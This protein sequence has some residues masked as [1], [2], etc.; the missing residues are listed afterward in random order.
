[1]QEDA[2]ESTL[3]GCKN[4]AELAKVFN[5]GPVMKEG[6]TEEKELRV[7]LKNYIT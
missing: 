1:M 3:A 5:Q 4:Q 2:N 6:V 7:T